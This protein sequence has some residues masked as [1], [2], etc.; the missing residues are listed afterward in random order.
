MIFQSPCKDCLVRP[1][2]K[3]LCSEQK[4]FLKFYENIL[5][6]IC[7]GFSILI[8][9][10]LILSLIHNI[11]NNAVLIIFILLI[12]IVSIIINI[13]LLELQ[14]KNIHFDSEFLS[15]TALC[16]ISPFMSMTFI[17]LTLYRKFAKIEAKLF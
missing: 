3:T 7:F 14:I 11:D 6:L 10:S 8:T 1:C 13:V 2:C 12:W 4:E 16:C 9:L 15:V 5:P 17:L